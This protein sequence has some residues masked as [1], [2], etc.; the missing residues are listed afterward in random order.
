LTI[1][2]P[3]TVFGQIQNK[4]KVVN[5]A[6]HKPVKEIYCYILKDNDKWIDIGQ[7][8]KKG[9]FTTHLWNL[10]STATYQ[11][12]ISESKFKPFRQSINPFDNKRL[13]VTIY[14]DSALIEKRANLTYLECSSISF[15]SY[16]PKEPHSIYDLPDSIRINLVAHLIDRLGQDFY[17]KLKISGGQILDLDRLYIVEDNAKNYQWTP[18]SYYL[19]FSFQDASK[20]IGLY[21][22]KIVLDKHG[23]VIDEIQLPNIKENPEKA[24][25]ISLEQA[26]GIALENKFYDDKTEISLSYDKKAGSITWCFKQT[27]YNSDHTLSGW[28]WVIDAHNGKIIG[29]YG[30]GGIWD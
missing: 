5:G 2:F 8:N 3:L 4:I 15:G 10:D 30:H 14:P 11:I 23:N 22:A 29:K 6:T 18:Y 16:H 17:S 19:C 27:T 25:I 13:T 1:L 9:I 12:D 20:G 26:K 21:T 28:T 24:T 7:T